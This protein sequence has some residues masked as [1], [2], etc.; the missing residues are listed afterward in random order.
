ME[1]RPRTGSSMMTREPFNHLSS[2]RC[3]LVS[4]LTERIETL[5]STRPLLL[6]SK[7]SDISMRIL[8]INEDLSWRS[9]VTLAKKDRVS[10]L[11]KNIM[12]RIRDG[13]SDTVKMTEVTSRE[14]ERMVIS[15]LSLM[16]LSMLSVKLTLS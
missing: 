8:L 10:L 16:S 4:M 5:S 3:H 9:K 6:G 15:D 12:V 11:G 14:K 7:H 2:Q 1:I 13:S